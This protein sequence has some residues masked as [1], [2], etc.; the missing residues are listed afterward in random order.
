MVPVTK[1]LYTEE[2]IVRTDELSGWNKQENNEGQAKAYPTIDWTQ[3]HTY[4]AYLPAG[5]DW[6]DYWTGQQ[7]EGGQ[8]VTATVPLN[9]SPL[10]VRAGAI[11]PIGP[12]VQY[13]AE[14]AWDDLEIRIYAGANGRF[15]LYEDEGDS[16][17]YERGIYTEIPFQW[18]EK[19]QTL[20]IG[21]RAGSFPG[22]LAQRRFRI[23][24]V[25]PQGVS[26]VH[27]IDYKGKA[28]SVR[29]PKS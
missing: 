22:M 29:F 4:E 15:T 21:K 11:L 26:P 14:K 8:T 1:P 20:T 12:D 27:T 16:Y 18:D 13:A 6:Y 19:S 17:R 9:H 7:L 28:V 23:I 10:Y 5:A 3:E 25:T 2:K 24:R